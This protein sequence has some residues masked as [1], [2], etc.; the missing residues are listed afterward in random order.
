MQHGQAK[1]QIK[2]PRG[3]DSG[4]NLRVQKKGHAGVGGAA[5]GDL[6]IQLKIRPHKLFQR[7]GANIYSDLYV[8]IG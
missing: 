7:Q 1:E 3:V 4:V 6:L 2:I 8:S 5:A